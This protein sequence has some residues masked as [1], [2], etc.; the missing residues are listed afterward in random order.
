[1]GIGISKSRNALRY[2]L[3]LRDNPHHVAMS[4]AVG[5]FIGISPFLGVHTIMGFFVAQYF[6]LNT[7]VTVSAVWI[8]NPWTLI[9]IYS[10][11]T[12]VGMKM[13]GVEGVMSNVQWKTMTMGSIARELKE[14]LIPFFLGNILVGFIAAVVGYFL[15][16]LLLKN[17]AASHD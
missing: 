8:T 10:F 15:I 6:R 14:L 4:F 1:M 5:T 17:S 7:F 16:Y 3:S 2:I 11:N 9:P 12:W 13:L